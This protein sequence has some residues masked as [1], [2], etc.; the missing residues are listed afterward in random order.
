MRAAP[1]LLALLC[2]LAIA[3][4]PTEAA[5]PAARIV[6]LAPHL[7]ELAFAAGAGDKLVGVS[8]YSDYPEAATGI[9]QIGD[10]GNIDLERVLALRPHL[11]L[12]WRSG[13]SPFALQTLRELG[14]EVYTSEPRRLSDIALL[15]REIGRRA[16][17]FAAAEAVAR[18]FETQLARLQPAAGSAVPAFIEVWGDPLVTVNGAHMMSDVLARCG[19][20]N[21]FADQAWL[22]PN[23]AL[24]SLLAVDPALIVG[25]GVLRESEFL[26]KWRAHRGLRA[27][28]TSQLCFVHPDIFQRSTPRILKGAQ[29]VCACVREA[30]RFGR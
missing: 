24:E 3:R 9:A 28:S 19:G 11:V 30:A 21:V 25:G 13:N 8:A 20:A 16:G 14:I 29:R 5:E 23:V 15:L 17:T 27:V 22:T 7:T 6:S 12:A 26:A 10:A 2:L 4:T 1:L 18:D